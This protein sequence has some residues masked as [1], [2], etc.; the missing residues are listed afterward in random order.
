LKYGFRPGLESIPLTAPVDAAH[1]VDPREPKLVL[2]VPAVEVMQ[3]A[4][5]SWLQ[6]K[7]HT[8]VILVFDRS[9]SM[10]AS[11]KLNNA[12]RGAREIIGM[13]GDE[14]RLGLLAFSTT[15]AWVEKGVTMKEGRQRMIDA[16]NGIF[17][18]GETA[19]YDTIAEAHEYLQADPQ[20]NFITAIIVLTDGEDN[21]SQLRLKEL[22]AKVKID[23]EKR[24]TRIYTIAYAADASEAAI[25]E[26]ILKLIAEATQAKSYNGTPENIKTIFKDIATFF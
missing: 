13:L 26:K 15:S 4:R 20:P 2:D 6:N 3:A 18:E 23:N 22:I 10:N 14:D 21:K 16:V 5:A 9:G 7:K 1:G 24:T 8:R 11:G 17:A 25:Y 19:L 12:K